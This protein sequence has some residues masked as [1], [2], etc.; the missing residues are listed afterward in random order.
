VVYHPYVKKVRDYLLTHGP[1][2]DVGV[3]SLCD[4]TRKHIADVRLHAP[5]TASYLTGR[6]SL[7]PRGQRSAVN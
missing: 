5:Q 7:P 4:F 6:S 1:S 3:L 2:F